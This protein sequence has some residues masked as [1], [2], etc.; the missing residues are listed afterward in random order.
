MPPPL[1]SVGQA[2]ARGSRELG[3]AGVEG[4]RLESVLLLGHVLGKT[5]VAL[6]TH[7]EEDLPSD[8][9]SRFASLC[10]R[11]GRGEPLA[12][13]VGHREFWSMDLMVDP[14]VL[15]PRPET[16]HLVEEVLR[17]LPDA[18]LRVI[19]YGT[20]S[21]CIAL[22]LARE[23]PRARLVAVD[24][25]AG[26]LAVASLNMRRLDL[27]QQVSLVQASSLVALMGGGPV[28]AIVSNPPYIP[29]SDL[30]SL[31]ATV[32]D[33]EP[34][35]AL[36]PGRD[37]LEIIRPLVEDAGRLL[38]KDGLLALE[39]AAD[40]AGAVVQL[41]GAERWTGVQVIADLAG[42]PRVVLGRRRAAQ[43]PTPRARSLLRARRASSVCG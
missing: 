12:Y 8:A 32:R 3:A 28:D 26:A 39:V 27:Q 10:A 2:L 4:A 31:P 30:A 7:P 36:T 37:G 29:S 25:D 43:K 35:R 34:W 42:R 14:R 24:V 11:R 41:L 20:G 5:K 19:D 17:R 18:P 6:W 9:A 13:L 22:A 15:I 40:G 38:S 21:G 1:L 23:R 16:E 33:H